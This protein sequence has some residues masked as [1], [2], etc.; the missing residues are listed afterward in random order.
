M[1]KYMI[2]FFETIDSLLFGRVTYQLMERYWPTASAPNDDP[3]I[4]DNMNNLPKL[5][6]QKR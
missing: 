3:I 6:F 5:F 2:S 1:D 4:T